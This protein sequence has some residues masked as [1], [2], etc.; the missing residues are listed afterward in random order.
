MYVQVER[1]KATVQEADDLTSLSIRAGSDLSIGEIERI[2]SAAGLVG[3]GSGPAG[4]G[5]LWL[6]IAA[7]RDVTAASAAA[8]EWHARFTEMITYAAG[9]GW[10]NE[11][12]S[13]VVA[14]LEREPGRV[15]GSSPE[16]REALK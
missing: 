2:L 15:S 4:Q 6:S 3:R 12:R 16:G 7:L 13:A 14:H 8:P 1:E 5:E 11:D 9:H 10:C